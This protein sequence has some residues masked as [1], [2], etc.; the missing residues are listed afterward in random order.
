LPHPRANVILPKTI[1]GDVFAALRFE[2]LK[3]KEGKAMWFLASRAFVILVLVLFTTAAFAQRPPQKRSPRVPPPAPTPAPTVEPSPEPNDEPQEVDTIK[4]DT[5][6]VT[7]PVIAT[8]RNGIYVPDLTKADFSLMEDG[9]G[10]EIA[11]FS[12]VTAPFTVVLLL[13][14]SASTQAKLSEIRRAAIAFVEQLQSKDKVKVISFNDTVTDHNEF[15]SDRALLRASINKVVAGEGTKLYDAF[16]SALDSLRNIQGRKAI[17][18]FSDGV[19]RVSD[20]ATF[21][22]SLR[23]LD[24][25]GVIV[26]PI[27]YDTRAETE[28]LVRRQA[29]EQGPSLPTIGVIRAPSGGTPTTFPSEDPNTV[30]SASRKSGPFGLPLPEEILRRRREEQR[31][32]DGG[33]PSVTDMPDATTRRPDDR[34]GDARGRETMPGNTTTRQPR[35]PDDSI[36]SMLDLAYSTADSYLKELERK[37]GG[38]L[39]RA[40]TLASLPDAFAK[41]AAELRTQYALGYYPANKA[42]DG[43]Y[44]R[45]KVSTTKK[46]VVIRARP[47]YSRT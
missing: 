38:R 47:G 9:K 24:E 26:Y 39:V 29:D 10:Q 33:V 16:A 43:K 21:D 42:R 8:D 3:L 15:T 22:S 20:L 30:P 36:T 44:R 14:T 25:E 23:G 11:F 18:L 31:R 28:A 5:D 6:V 46:D 45:I 13:D 40:D 17:V 35:S 37:S 32:Q 4:V 27:R 1:V 7:V 41:I 12:T 19:D 2:L 34:T